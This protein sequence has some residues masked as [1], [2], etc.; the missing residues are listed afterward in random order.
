MGQAVGDSA[1]APFESL[2]S[3]KAYGVAREVQSMER[4]IVPVGT[5]DAMW[6]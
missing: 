5:A 3:K 1:G 6:A 2:Y 4:Y